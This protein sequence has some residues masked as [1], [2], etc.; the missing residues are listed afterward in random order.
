MH[1]LKFGDGVLLGWKDGGKKLFV[2]FRLI[3]LI[4]EELNLSNG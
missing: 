2:A 3:K 1:I 4:L